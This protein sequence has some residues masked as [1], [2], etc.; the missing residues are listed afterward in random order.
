MSLKSLPVVNSD[1]GCLLDEC[2]VKWFQD[3]RLFLD[4]TGIYYYLKNK[5]YYV[6]DQ[7]I[8]LATKDGLKEPPANR[9]I[10]YEHLMTK[11]DPRVRK[12]FFQ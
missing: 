9:A 12:Y 1:R 10:L 7:V 2:Y 6:H 8:T 5:K 11:V 4:G 3:K